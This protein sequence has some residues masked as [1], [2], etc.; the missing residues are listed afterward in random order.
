MRY[1][2]AALLIATPLPTLAQAPAAGISTDLHV[3]QTLRD[4]TGT[5]IG[6]IDR[7]FTDG[8][9][10]VILDAKLVVI[11]ASTISIVNGKPV[12][13]LSRREASSRS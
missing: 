7:V 8:S 2:L 4:P 5:K 6:K 1:M 11:P 9:V 10:R 13:T 12:T 3:G